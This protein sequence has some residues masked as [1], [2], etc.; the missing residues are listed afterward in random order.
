MTDI[1]R[2]LAHLERR[3]QELKKLPLS[4]VHEATGLTTKQLLRLV[5]YAEAEAVG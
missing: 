3:A 2:R 5:S 1:Q 4:D